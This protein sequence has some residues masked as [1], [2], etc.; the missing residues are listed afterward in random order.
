MTATLCAH[1]HVAP[2]SAT[3]QSAWADGRGF[4]L[5]A[6]VVE[7]DDT[8]FYVG[9]QNLYI[10]NLA[11]FGLIVDDAST[12]Q[13]FEAQFLNNVVSYSSSRAVSGGG[14][15]CGAGPT[16]TGDDGGAN[17]DAGNG[18]G[19]DGGGAATNEAGSG[20]DGGAVADGV[21]A[22]IPTCTG[23]P[24]GTYCGFDQVGGEP[25]TVYTCTGGQV[26]FWAVCTNGCAMG[27][28]GANDS[29]N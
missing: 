21:A 23:L 3:G 25:G 24:D 13:D 10:A 14:S 19:D 17:P 9:S 20:N 4:A 26:V 27:D 8:A 22:P 18:T 12:T 2:L 29:C 11:E 6:K 1:L 16:P 15:S 5:H 28:S 7:V